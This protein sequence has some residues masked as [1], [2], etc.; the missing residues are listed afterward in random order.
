MEKPEGSGAA[1]EENLSEVEPKKE[2]VSY[3]TYRRVVT[4]VK[5]AK[6]AVA[7]LMAEKEANETA[8]MAEQNKWK[9]LAEKLQKDLKSKEDEIKRKD[10]FVIQSNLKGAIGRFAKDMGASEEAIDEIFVVAKSKDLLNEIEVGQDYSVNGDQVK[11]A[12]AEL[13]KKSPWFF[14]KQVSPPKDV[15][16]GSKPSGVNPKDLEKLSYDELIAL[17]KKAK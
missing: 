8:R 6:D 4:E 12:L 16:V 2:A 3:D 5:K 14:T 15:A 7:Q 11:N 9:E 1:T 17:G 13:Q 10:A